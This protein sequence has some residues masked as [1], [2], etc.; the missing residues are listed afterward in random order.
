MWVPNWREQRGASAG[1]CACRSLEA[2]APTPTSCHAPLGLD[3]REGQ[4]KI[5][6]PWMPAS[7]K[8]L[9]ECHSRRSGVAMSQSG[10]PFLKGRQG[11]PRG[12][13]VRF[14]RR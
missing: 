1:L 10:R 4:A 12:G 5:A 11:S 3:W 7:G 8:C 9:I 2:E 13:A 6:E 14:V